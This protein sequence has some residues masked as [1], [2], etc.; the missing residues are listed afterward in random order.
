[1]AR[2]RNRNR[3]NPGSSM[4][5][6]GDVVDI[7]AIAQQASTE[8]AVNNT[9]AAVSEE[10]AAT[11]Q[12]PTSP[13]TEGILNDVLDVRHSSYDL[14][15]PRAGRIKSDGPING[16]NNVKKHQAALRLKEDVLNDPIGTAGNNYNDLKLQQDFIDISNGKQS[17]DPNFKEA[18][19]SA[20]ADMKAKQSNNKFVPANRQANI[21]DSN[22]VRD[23]EAMMPPRDFVPADRVSEAIGGS[24]DERLQML[25]HN[26]G[27][28]YVKSEQKAIARSQ[29]LKVAEELKGQKA[30]EKVQKKTAQY[31]AEAVEQTAKRATQEAGE[32]LL[33]KMA[34]SR[35]GRLAA[36]LGVTAFLVSNMNKNKGQQSNAELYGQRSPYQ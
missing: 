9:V 22:K 34:H 25:D 26:N 21:F 19:N 11:R 7:N 2:R 27:T 4:G 17:F 13:D 15:N 20:K 28:K 31:Q 1:M 35:Y 32:G 24:F 18:I 36:G 8:A 3:H 30:L 6:I 12:T 14:P 33:G 16:M 23:A 5:T 29:K 10:I